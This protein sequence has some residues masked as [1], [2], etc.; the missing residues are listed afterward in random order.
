MRAA[1]L[2]AALGLL[3]ALSAC[4]GMPSDNGKRFTGV[5]G[6]FQGGTATGR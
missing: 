5:Y 3:A 1:R 2:I 4:A 6:G